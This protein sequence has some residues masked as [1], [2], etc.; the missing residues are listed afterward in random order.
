MSVGACRGWRER[1]RRGG[2]SAGPQLAGTAGVYCLENRGDVSP[3][4]RRDTRPALCRVLPGAK[5]D[6]IRVYTID[7]YI[8][9]PNGAFKM[10]D[11]K[12]ANLGFSLRKVGF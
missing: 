7:V 12:G 3:L 5:P 9:P 11:W 10:R 4:P 2:G 6:C 8:L 1:G